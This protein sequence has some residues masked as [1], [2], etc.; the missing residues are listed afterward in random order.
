MIRARRNFL[1]L[2]SIATAFSA[3]GGV[4]FEAAEEAALGLILINPPIPS[5]AQV[6]YPTGVRFLGKAVGLPGGVAEPV[7]AGQ[8]QGVLGDGG[9]GGHGWSSMVVESWLERKPV[10]T[11]R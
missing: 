6:L 1:K 7:A 8:G 10:R 9:A 4:T 5:D 2:G 3:M 11:S